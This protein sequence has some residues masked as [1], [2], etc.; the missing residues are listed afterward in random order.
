MAEARDE[1]EHQKYATV[2][3]GR[4]RARAHRAFVEIEQSCKSAIERDIESGPHGPFPAAL[5]LRLAL[6]RCEASEYRAQNSGITV[7]ATKYEAN[8]EITTASANAVNKNLLT[9]YKKVTGKKTTTVVSVAA[10]TARL[11][12]DPP[13]S[14]A[15]S[16]RR[17]LSRCR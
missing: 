7:M 12:S 2:S 5:P 9:P 10:S 11:T 6:V 4:W 13:S 3:P 17:A 15:R 1:H 16:R 8:S 14:A